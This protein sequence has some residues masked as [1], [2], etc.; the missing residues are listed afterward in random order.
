MIQ[1][2]YAGVV[3]VV[4]KKDGKIYLAISPKMITHLTGLGADLKLLNDIGDDDPDKRMAAMF[5]SIPRKDAP[6]E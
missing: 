4:F 2:I 6:A 3:Y 5:E 1:G